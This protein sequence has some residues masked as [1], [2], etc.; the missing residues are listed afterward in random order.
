MTLVFCGS[1]ENPLRYAAAAL[2]SDG[3]VEITHQA[4]GR[5]QFRIRFYTLIGLV[6]MFIHKK[7]YD[8]LLSISFAFY[9]SEVY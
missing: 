5:D 8:D 1:A 3:H 9:F 4:S 7:K 2:F 6:I